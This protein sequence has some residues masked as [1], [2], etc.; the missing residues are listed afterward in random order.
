KAMPQIEKTISQRY[1][2]K[3]GDVKKWLSLTEWGQ[4]NLG[5]FEVNKVQKKLLQLQLIEK[6][7]P[8]TK[9]LA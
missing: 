7:I 2:Q 8:T 6:E 3:L 4:Q 1:G 9:I 5:P